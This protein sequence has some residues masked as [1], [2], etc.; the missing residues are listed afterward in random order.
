MPARDALARTG[1]VLLQSQMTVIYSNQAL[2][3]A[4]AS[5]PLRSAMAVR[6]SSSP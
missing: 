3:L 1:Q 4:P 6:H 5:L 2:S